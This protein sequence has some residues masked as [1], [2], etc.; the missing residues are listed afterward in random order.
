MAETAADILVD[1]LIEWEVTEVFGLPGDGINGVMETLRKRQ[2][3]IRFIHVRHEESAACMA[4]AY[5]KYTGKLGVC[6]ATSG[7]GGIHLLNGLYDAKLD[8]QPVLAITGHAFHDLIDTHTQQDVDLD[9]LF[10]DVTVYNA[11]VMG[12]AHVRNVT[13]LAC[14]TAL[15]FRGVAHLNIPADIQDEESDERSKRNI[16][17]HTASVTARGARLAAENDLSRAAEILNGGKKIAILVGQ[18]ALDARNEVI[19]VAE[20]L[21]AP[22]IK[23]LLG[24]AVVP[25]DCPY[26]TGGVGLLGTKASQEAL[27]DCD[28]LLIAG[29]S[30]P[31]IEYYPEPGKARAVQIDIDPVRIGLRYPVELGIVADCRSALQHLL[32]N[33]KATKDRD[34]LKKARKEV[35]K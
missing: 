30:F 22:I 5:A 33:L 2:D 7:P 23:A 18:G 14:R 13:D 3:K 26:T 1:R 34:F 29:S 9:R 27:E 16:A 21:A 12:C 20:R 31:Y 32:P 8:G 15:N 17:N 28:T 19:A 4:C 10:T 35:K 6:L 11:R 25:D 24:K